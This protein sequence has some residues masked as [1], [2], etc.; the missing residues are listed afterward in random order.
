MKRRA[1]TVLV[2]DDDP[3]I[4][5]VLSALLEQAHLTSRAAACGAE[6]LR[7]LEEQIVDV[8]LT[9]VRMPGLDGLDLLSRI[10]HEWPDLPVVVLTAHGSVPM[11]VE[12]MRRGAHD[13]LL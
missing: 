1:A 8:V 2:V 9:D 4:V 6:A 7:L 5:K 11:A 3:A 12:A 10:V 13:F